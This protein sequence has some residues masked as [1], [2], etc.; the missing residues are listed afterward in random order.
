[1]SPLR[2]PGSK[3]KILPSIHQLIEGNMPKPELFVE[4][5]CGGSSIALGL[6]EMDAVNRVLLS[7]YDPL[8]AAFWSEAAS[9]ADRL[10]EDMMKEPVTVERWDFWRTAKPRSTRKK[11][12]K[13][14]F[15]NRTTFSSIIGSTAGPI[16]GRAQTSEYA[17]G[18]RFQKEPLARRIFNIKNLAEEGRIVGVHHAR[19]QDAVRHAEEAAIGFPDK[20]TIF[21]LD[22][23]YVEKASR[24]YELLFTNQDHRALA[25]YLTQQSEH[26]WILSYDEE[27]L[28]L[29]LYRGQPGVSE[30][31]VTHHYTMRGNRRSPVPGRE[32][33][34][35]NLPVDP[36]D[37]QLEIRKERRS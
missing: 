9:N 5:F 32:I 35:T 30:F 33:L 24:I 23:P 18:C 12:S 26:R 8:V 27:P 6:L 7:D 19:W 4:P 11:A 10:V 21:Y 29:D 13:C 20:A 25:C 14:L 17:I 22:P 15:L 34:F 31:S 3:R 37:T 28:I 2:Y 36:T 1:M 16:G